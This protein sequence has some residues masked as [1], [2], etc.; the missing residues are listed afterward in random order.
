MLMTAAILFALGALGGLFMATRHFQGRPWPLAVA[1]IHG[2]LGASGLVLLAWVVFHGLSSGGFLMVSLVLFV[3]A[4]LGGVVLFTGHLRGRP[5]ST[6]L[7]VIHAAVAVT[8]F[9]LLLLSL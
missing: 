1:V 2:L 7:L 5:L 8:G 6:P 4:A 9:I 3:V